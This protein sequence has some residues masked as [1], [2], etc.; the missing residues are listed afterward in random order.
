MSTDSIIRFTT[1]E[2][3]PTIVIEGKLTG[4]ASD[5]LEQVLPAIE[6]TKAQAGVIDLEN[7]EYINSTGIKILLLVLSKMEDLKMT[8]F[9]IKCPERVTRILDLVGIREHVTLA[10]SQ[11]SVRDLLQKPE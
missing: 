8:P 4:E 10:D 7:V 9:I 6:Q 2:L 1:E 11:E 5:R 3:Y